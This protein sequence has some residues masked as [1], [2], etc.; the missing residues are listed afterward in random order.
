[1]SSDLFAPLPGSVIPGPVDREAYDGLAAIYD[2]VM[3]HVDYIA[4]TDHIHSLL[5][6]HGRDVGRLV[7]LAC[8]TGNATFELDRLG[9]DI[10]GYDA[11]EAMIRL[12]RQKADF[13]GQG[14]AF[15]VRDL[16]EVHDLG[17]ADAAICLYDSF[18]YL[19]T[20]PDI[21]EALRA[22]H[23]LLSPEGI[24]IFDVCTERNSLNHFL[25]VRE[26]EDGP[27]F[28]YSRHSSYDRDRRL[29]YNSF[30][31]RFDDGNI[32]VRETHSQRIYS[33]GE[34]VGRIEASEFELVAA[35]DGF[36]LDDG[37]DLSD[38]VHFVLRS[39]GN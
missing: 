3:R 21:D 11:S 27:G 10:A 33:H 9:Y 4:W 18:N 2:Y 29:Q 8:G 31:I 6:R 14:V 25:D 34:L 28:V 19:L 22:V 37:S 36:T 26:A 17:P 38:R 39:S 15:D 32:H 5:Q 12:A 30:D 1:M 35:Y 24:F 20:P 16:R 13:L 23:R 7:E